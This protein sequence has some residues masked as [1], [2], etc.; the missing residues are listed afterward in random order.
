MTPPPAP[1]RWVPLVGAVLFAAAHTQPPL[2]YSNQNQY[3]LHGLAAA[4]YGDLGRDWLAN[5]ADPTPAFS[6]FVALAYRTL[7]EWPFQAAF[8]VL[9]IVYFLSLWAVVAVLPFRPVTTA[10]RAALAAVLIVVHAGIVRA[11]SVWLVGVDYPWYLQAGV[12]NQYLLGPG[13]QPSAFGVLLLAALAAFAHGRPMAAG[14]LAAAACAM[15]ST[16]LLPAG[17]L[18][19][20]MMCSPLAPRADSEDRSRS[21]RTTFRAALVTGAV[22]LL[23][24]L[25]V[26]AYTLAVFAP[27][28]PVRFAQAQAIIAWVRIPHHTVVSQWLD[29]VAA[30]HLVWLAAGVVAFRR[31]PLFVPL[32]AAAVLGLALSVVQV[33]TE[34]AT[35]ALLFPWRVSAVLVP[36]ATAAA[37]AGLAR[38]AERT[39]PP[40]LLLILSG[41]MAVGAVVGAGVV[42]WNQLG[43]QQTA[44]E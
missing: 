41:L 43:Y 5:T 8:V 44:A 16:Y 6:A 26:V 18:V 29:G 38:L 40:R 31:T 32:A 10:G 9:L 39:V 33:L 20:G 19:A 27:T 4:G 14:L 22:A 36:V 35:L 3:F 11:G 42:Y 34:S 28:D 21:E 2:Y 7:G 24:V 17:L 30:L 25:P 37:A 1:G 13:L 23:G 15:H 12:A